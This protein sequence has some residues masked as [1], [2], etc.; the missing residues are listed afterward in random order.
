M[1]TI[2]LALCTAF[3]GLLLLV[4]GCGTG[5]ANELQLD[6]GNHV[7]MDLVKTPRGL[8]WGKFEVTLEQWEAVVRRTSPVERAR[9]IAP[10]K[11]VYNVSFD[12]VDEFLRKLNQMPAVKRRGL[13][14]RLPDKAEWDLACLAGSSGPWPMMRNGSAGSLER[15]AWYK[16]DDG[17]PAETHPVGLKEPNAYGLYDM[18]GNVSELTTTEY[19][20][21]PWEN[22]TDRGRWS[23]GGNVDTSK[24]KPD[25]AFG[26]WFDDAGRSGCGVTG[27]G[28]YLYCGFRVCA[29]SPGYVPPAKSPTIKKDPFHVL[30]GKGTS[31]EGIPAETGSPGVVPSGASGS[32]QRTAPIVQPGKKMTDEEIFAI[33]KKKSDQLLAAGDIAGARK[34]LE[35]AKALVELRNEP[36]P[37][38]KRRRAEEE[39]AERAREEE[40]RR[41]AEEERLQME[42]ERLAK[43]RQEKE[44]QERELWEQQELQKEAESLRQLNA[45]V[46]KFRLALRPIRLSLEVAERK[47]TARRLQAS[48]DLLGAEKF[49]QEAEK[50][51]AEIE[52]LSPMRYAELSSEARQLRV[53]LRSFQSALVNSE[54]GRSLSPS[55]QKLNE[56]I[57]TLASW[58][59][60]V[61]LNLDKLKN[62]DEPDFAFKNMLGNYIILQR[63]R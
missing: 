19:E 20:E 52:V 24:A 60:E 56:D 57:D 38:E 55:T 4:I 40:R 29:P 10:D 9:D 28:K 14:F 62:G 50:R 15:M 35:D 37:E 16:M 23:A 44:R 17:M 61:A 49:L 36:T 33:A 39:A 6:L 45:N 48:G 12:D 31:E 27:N 18:L 26:Y 51:Q 46:E 30:G 21:P 25:G 22:G 43:E 41:K 8:W 42:R 3:Y 59:Q 53:Q 5:S 13:S 1:T 7:I 2:K 54:F 34:V 47:Q 32:P 63:K 11:P 58:L